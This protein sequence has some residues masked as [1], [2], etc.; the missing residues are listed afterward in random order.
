L[1]LFKLLLSKLSNQEDLVVG[2]PIS[3]RSHMDLEGIVGVF[4]NT[5]AIRSHPLGTQ[6]YQAYLSEVKSLV[7]SA[8]EHQHYQYEDLIDQLA[9]ARDTSRNPLFDVMFSYA[10]ETELN[11]EAAGD[12][13][14]P[15]RASAKVDSK[16]DL[17][18]MV[19]EGKKQASISLSYSTSLFDRSSIEQFLSY[20]DVIIE[21]VLSNPAVRLGSISLLSDEEEAAQLALSS[22]EKLDYDAG[23]TVLDL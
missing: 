2:T 22:G 19:V 18:M 4:V 5:L 15:Y 20:F 16:F 1:S 3:G 17:T 10:T 6:T 7:L 12:L 21:S 13:I 9:L 8:F 11:K 23:L 14:R